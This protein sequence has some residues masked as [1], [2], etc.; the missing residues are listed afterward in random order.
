ME[1]ALALAH[2]DTPP[3]LARSVVAAFGLTRR[4]GA[5]ETAVTRFA[6]SRSRSRAATSLR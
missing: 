1:A 4:Y 3:V 5:G 6:A 2:P